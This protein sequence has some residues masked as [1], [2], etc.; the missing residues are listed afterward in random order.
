M[1]KLVFAAALAAAMTLP[2]VASAQ[3]RGDQATGWYVGASVG[4]AKA[5]TACDGLSGSG[6]TC[7]DTDTTWK[8]FGG[9]QFNRNLAAELGYSDFGK[10][11]A[12]AGTLTDE[13]KATAWELVGIGALPVADRFSVYGK[14]GLYHAETKETTNFVGNF[15]DTNNDLTFGF[16]ARYDF[17]QNVGVRAEWQRYKDVGG[18]SVGKDDFDVIS[19]GVVWRFR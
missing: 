18:S 16:G 17:T 8:L 7:D 11:K 10:V 13:V 19:V 9:Y 15:K 1:K 12:S 3:M 4:Q 2:A 5:K 14:L 6:I